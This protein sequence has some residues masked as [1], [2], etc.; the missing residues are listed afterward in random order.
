M[1][2]RII[3]LAAA[4]T[5]AIAA[6]VIMAPPAAHSAA[7]AIQLTKIYYDSPGRDRG[8][9]ASLNDEYVRLTNRGRH[10]VDLRGWTV[11]DKAGHTYRFSTSYRLAPGEHVYLHTG[12]AANT[13]RHRYWG[14]SWYVWNN[15]GDTAYLRNSAG[16]LVDR[17]SWGR[18]GSYTTC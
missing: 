14:R 8:S 2:T 12:R 16:T 9:N 18:G 15:T 4:L 5:I 7:P 3:G 11:R 13:S 1:R 10:T 17:C 6:S